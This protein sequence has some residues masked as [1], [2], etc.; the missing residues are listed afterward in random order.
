MK[1]DTQK[2]LGILY[3]K[4]EFKKNDAYWIWPSGQLT[5]HLHKKKMLQSLDRCTYI[6]YPM[7]FR[8][9]EYH[10]FYKKTVLLQKE[11]LVT[12]NTPQGRFRVNINGTELD[13]TLREYML[14]VGENTI[15]VQADFCSTLPAFYLQG[16]SVRTDETWQA[17]LEAREWTD[18][19]V[20]EIL[21][22]KNVEPLTD[23]EVDV[24]IT[25]FEVLSYQNC[26]ITPKSYKI[27]GGHLFLDVAYYEISVMSFDVKGTGSLYVGVGQC[28]EDACT[29]IFEEMEQ[30]PF[31]EIQL[32][33][34]IQHIVLPERCIKVIYL[35]AEGNCTIENLVVTARMYPVEYRGNFVSKDKE[36]NNIWDAS[37]A[38][39][40]T[41][42]HDVFVDGIYRDA[43]SWGL[44]GAAGISASDLMF[45]DDYT[46]KNMAI[47]Q[48][49]PV[50]PKLSDMG[51]GYL[52]FPMHTVL[53][54]EYYCKNRDAMDFWKKH[55][56][57]VYDILEIFLDRLDDKGFLYADL[58]G[59]KPFFIEWYKE[60]SGVDVYG[61]PTFAQILLAHCLEV[62]AEFAFKTQQNDIAERY[63]N[64]AE[65]IKQ[66][67]Q[68]YL[69][70]ET[71]GLYYNGYD[72]NHQLDKNFSLY[73]QTFAATYDLL[74]EKG[75]KSLRKM[76]WE[77]KDFERPNVSLAQYWEMCA[78]VKCNAGD[79]MLK[80]VKRYAG[81]CLEKG[82]NRIFEHIYADA[83][84]LDS[85]KF[86]GRKF[87]CS[88]CHHV[89]ADPIIVGMIQACSGFKMLE[90]GYQQA[91]FNPIELSLN[92]YSVSFATMLGD[93][94]VCKKENAVYE[95]QI[96]YGM[97]VQLKEY[98]TQDGKNT[99]SQQGTYIVRKV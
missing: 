89:L 96:P 69:Y 56:T 4:P 28:K 45:F 10:A 97:K 39:L 42:M 14:P 70:C 99:L 13:I 47:S 50:N 75:M 80:H 6:G 65:R 23:R 98:V 83:S 49:L 52:D 8:H 54:F 40:H 21:R 41:C 63:K 85:L 77:N 51:S 79:L 66:S 72:K 60:D 74:N 64:N 26:E 44:D 18:C 22:D 38:T 94:R 33:E 95:I 88:V 92:E 48:S 17:S 29:R 46:S 82:Y 3:K 27:N 35:Q 91:E 93:V 12:W 90:Y 1:I 84:P 87:A 19:E 20:D 30:Y 7:G 36:L 34:Q 68:K 62:A 25:T 5:A 31:E 9:P 55:C 37:V 67:I 61:A 71:T 57:R 43:L 59:N 11:E 73:A 86:Y 15:Y 58:Q 81:S 24:P 53:C 32:T 16:E 2:D 78:F 76:F